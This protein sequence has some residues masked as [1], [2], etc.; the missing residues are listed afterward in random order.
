M[1]FRL[2]VKS[3]LTTVFFLEST[4]R[5]HFGRGPRLQRDGAGAHRRQS[6]PGG[7]IWCKSVS[8]YIFYANVC[9]SSITVFSSIRL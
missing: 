4:N 3:L 1:L 5:A 9:H 7:N 8:L 2:S 6:K